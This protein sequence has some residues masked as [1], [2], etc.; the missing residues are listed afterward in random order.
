MRQISV[1]IVICPYQCSSLLTLTQSVEYRANL[2]GEHKGFGVN[3]F[4]YAR[5]EVG[6]EGHKSRLSPS[7][8]TLQHMPQ[9][10]FT[11]F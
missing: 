11:T 6:H 7:R 5:V 10:A 4:Y 2:F 3:R 8:P 1:G 9:G